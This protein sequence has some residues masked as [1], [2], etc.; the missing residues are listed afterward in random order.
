MK[1]AVP[2]R[3]ALADK[4]LLGATLAGESWQAWRVLLIA[5]M[6]E[7]LE[8]DERLIFRQLTGRAFEAE[9]RVEELCIVAGRRGGKSRALST[10]ACYIAALCDH[11]DVLA[12]G[13]TGVCLLVAPDQRQAK[14]DLDYCAAVFEH[15]PILRK[16]VANRTSDTLIELCFFC[17]TDPARRLRPAVQHRLRLGRLLFGAAFEANLL[18]RSREL[19]SITIRASP[20]GLSIDRIYISAA[21]P[22]IGT[23]GGLHR[24]PELRRYS[25]DAGRGAADRSQNFTQ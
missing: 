1:A 17:P 9:R 4:D 6:G 11:T 16:L 10:L 25:R 14:I 18:S 20:A 12:P 24:K 15:S 8:D 21:R 2:I 19:V 22:A 7:E 13:E 3:R 23:E 5:A